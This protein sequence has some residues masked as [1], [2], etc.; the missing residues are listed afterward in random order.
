MDDPRAA[1][2]LDIV[3]KETLVDRSKLVPEATI[4]SLGIAS[5]DIIQTIFALET[6]FDIE[7]PVAGERAGAEFSTVKELVDHVI[8][9]LD[10]V[11][12]ARLE[13]ETQK[14]PATQDGE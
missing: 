9:E 12:K 1:R 8:A 11:A 6:E 7:I 14:H 2:I 10:R 5:L 4:D 3:A 13:K